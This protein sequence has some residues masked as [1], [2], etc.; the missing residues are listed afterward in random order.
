M[1]AFAAFYVLFFHWPPPVWG[2]VLEIPGVAAFRSSGWTAVYFFF[3][4]SGFIMSYAYSRGG[5]RSVKAGA[6]YA[7]RAARIYPAHLLALL[8]AVPVA[9][10]NSWHAPDLYGGTLIATLFQYWDPT[11]ALK[12]NS[13]SWSLSVEI[14]FYLVFPLLFPL[15]RRL[16]TAGAVGLLIASVAV[17]YVIGHMALLADGANANPPI[18][19]STDYS[20]WTLI[21]DNPLGKLPYF[22]VGMAIAQLMLLHPRLRASSSSTWAVVIAT[23]LYLALIG[24]W[25]DYR[26]RHA[27]LAAPL[28]GLVVFCLATNRGW[29]VRQLERPT[30]RYLGELSYGIYL[31]HFILFRGAI[32]LVGKGAAGES[33][34]LGLATFAVLMAICALSYRY[35]ET[36]VRGRVRA[37]VGARAAAAKAPI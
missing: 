7:L 28:F 31:F 22:L 32:K 37:W 24:D 23:L 12:W 10:G 13:P 30:L 8:V 26:E 34:W 1:R 14:A 18:A 33:P 35:L 15:V 4:L 2:A 20:M 29:L 17:L 36:A 27:V 3:V 21:R 16:K 6:F 25:I 11:V 5:E 9:F 19:Q